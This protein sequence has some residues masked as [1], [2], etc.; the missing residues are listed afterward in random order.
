M[1][2]YSYQLTSPVHAF[3]ASDLASTSRTAEHVLVF[4]PLASQALAHNGPE[5]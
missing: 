4:S 2:E 3:D 5:S 1:I